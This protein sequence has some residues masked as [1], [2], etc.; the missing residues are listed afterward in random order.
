[1]V[2]KANTSAW[3]PNSKCYKVLRRKWHTVKEIANVS[4]TVGGDRSFLF[5]LFFFLTFYVSQAF[6]DMTNS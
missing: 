4:L 3:T 1:M 2:N 5:C 6:I